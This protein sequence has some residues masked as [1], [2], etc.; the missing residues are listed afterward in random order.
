MALLCRLARTR[1]PIYRSGSRTDRAFG[2][3][4]T[5]SFEK[6][7]FFAPCPSG[8]HLSHLLPARCIDFFNSLFGDRS[9]TR[10]LFLVA[11]ASGFWGPFKV[12]R[13]ATTPHW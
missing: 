5:P 2:L 1:A 13:H 8:G 10:L 3:V 12:A 6:R 9:R 11:P 7:R 4:I